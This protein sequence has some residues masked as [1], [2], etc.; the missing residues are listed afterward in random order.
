MA[1]CAVVRLA[2]FA[3]VDGYSPARALAIYECLHH[4][5]HTRRVFTATHWQ[6]RE[7]AIVFQSCRNHLQGSLRV[8]SLTQSLKIAQLGFYTETHGKV[9]IRI[10]ARVRHKSMHPAEEMV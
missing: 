1:G 3:V 5:V 10:G 4:T 6:N 2:L 9:R 8:I 7:N